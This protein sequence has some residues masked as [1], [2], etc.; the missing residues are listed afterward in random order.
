M[1]YLD[2]KGKIEYADYINEAIGALHRGNAICNKCNAIMILNKN[3]EYVCPE[4]HEKTSD[5]LYKYEGI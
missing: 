3:S 4:C 2:E 5:C 1:G